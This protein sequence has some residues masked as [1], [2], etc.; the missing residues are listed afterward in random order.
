MV[1]YRYLIE[2][3]GAPNGIC[4]SITE[5]KH[6]KAVKEPWRRSSRH[7]ALGQMLVINQ[8]IDKLHASRVDFK[9]RGMLEGP[10]LGFSVPAIVPALPIAEDDEDDDNELPDGESMPS[11]VILARRK[12]KLSL[13]YD[14]CLTYMKSVASAWLPSP[15]W[16]SWYPH[17][18]AHLPS[19]PTAVSVRPAQP[20]SCDYWRGRHN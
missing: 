13:V 4:S 9:S 2:L 16:T 8:R 5:S 11:S 3:F 15:C 17:R 1:H 19:S 6:I 7:A 10:C 14:M 20:W 12:G 18:P